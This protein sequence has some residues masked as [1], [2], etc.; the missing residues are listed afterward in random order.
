MF[1][2]T[3]HG[4]PSTAPIGA[5]TAPGLHPAY[6]PKPSTTNCAFTEP[7]TACAWGVSL[8]VVIHCLLL[9]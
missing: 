2:L 9:H 3:L 1:E 6:S 5:L 8:L 7:G 4:L